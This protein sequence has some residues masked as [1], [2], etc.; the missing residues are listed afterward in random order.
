[1][2]CHGECSCVDAQGY[3]IGAF[4]DSNLECRECGSWLCGVCRGGQPQPAPR[5]EAQKK[6][7][8]KY[9]RLAGSIYA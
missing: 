5:T 4:E 8:A 2:D 6:L 7:L 9:L 1:M 3:C